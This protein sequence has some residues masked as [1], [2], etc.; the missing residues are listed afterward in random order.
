M[1]FDDVKWMLIANNPIQKNWLMP[2]R[3]GTIDDT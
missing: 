3:F 2:F 1:K